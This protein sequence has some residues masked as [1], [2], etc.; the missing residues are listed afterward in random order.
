MSEEPLECAPSSA[1]CSP[2]STK[3]TISVDEE[4]QVIIE[5]SE[6][7]SCE[8][9]SSPR[10]EIYFKSLPLYSNL[11]TLVVRLKPQLVSLNNNTRI[12]AEGYTFVFIRV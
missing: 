12:K 1:C 11:A 9:K 8:E 3:E 4:K 10:F 6:A 5:C 7:D 2:T